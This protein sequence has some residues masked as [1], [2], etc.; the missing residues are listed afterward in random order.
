MAYLVLRISR[1]IFVLFY[2]D[3]LAGRLILGK[4]ILVHR[5]GRP[6]RIVGRLRCD[7][8]CDRIAWSCDGIGEV[9]F[10]KLIDLAAYVNSV[11]AIHIEVVDGE[12]VRLDLLEYRYGI[13]CARNRIT[14]YYRFVG[15]L[16]FPMVENL[17]FHEGII[18]Q[19]RDLIAHSKIHEILGFLTDDLAIVIPDNKGYA[20]LIFEIRIER[21][22]LVYRR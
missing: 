12:L 13:E 18:G 8:R 19:R 15:I 20:D 4:L 11:L 21:Q 17:A 22:I 10:H 7:L 2:A 1:N 14:Y 6:A 3:I 9:P 5:D 16:I